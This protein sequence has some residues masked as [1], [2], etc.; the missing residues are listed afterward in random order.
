MPKRPY[1]I[2]L[3]C[4]GFIL[5]PP[6]CWCQ[7]YIHY[8]IE[9]GLP[10]NHVY[11]IEQDMQGFMWFATNMG[12]VKFD[13]KKFK[14]FTTESGL[15]TNDIWRIE[16]TANG[17][18]WYFAKSR[19]LG[20]IEND[21]VYTFPI[22][23]GRVQTPRIFSHYENQIIFWGEADSL[24]RGFYI[25]ENS[26]WHIRTKKIA[27]DNRRMILPNQNEIAVAIPQKIYDKNGKYL[28]SFRT[29]KNEALL[30]DEAAKDINKFTFFPERGLYFVLNQKL[31]SV[32]NTNDSTLH[33][34]KLFSPP[35]E[36]LTG[37]QG[38]PE[39]QQYGNNFQISQ[40]NEWAL[41][42]EKLNIIEYKYFPTKYPAIHTFK[43]KEGNFWLAG[44]NFGIIA[45]PQ[46]NLDNKYYF[47]DEK[48]QTVNYIQGK[49][50]VNTLNNGW[51]VYNENE[52]KFDLIINHVGKIYEMGY[53]KK[54]GIYY[55]FNNNSF[56]YG[57][58]LLHIKRVTR[59]Q[60][61][62]SGRDYKISIWAGAKTLLETPT[63]F[64]GLNG[65]RYFIIFDRNFSAI[66]NEDLP[67]VNGSKVLLDFKNKKYMFGDGVKFL[68]EKREIK[69]PLLQ[70]PINTAVI[71]NKDWILVGTEGFGAY[72]YDGG[73]TTYPLI[74][75]EGF[76]VNKII[77]D[78]SD[79]WIATSKGVH[80][81]TRH[82]NAFVQS[83]TLYD[84]DGLLNN[85]IN[86]ICLVGNRLFIAHDEGL[87]E[88]NL[89]Q[90]QFRKNVKVYFAGHPLYN[91]STKTLSIKYGN[92]LSLAFGVLCLP[93]QRYIK[94]Y[95]KLNKNEQ[96]QST[97]V[98]TLVV[99][100]QP[101]GQYE[102]S[103]KAIDQHNNVGETKIT[104]L[105]LPLWYQT[106]AFKIITALSIILAIVSITILYRKRIE[107]KRKAELVLSKTLSELE[108]K[109]LRSQMNPHFV[110]N[111][112]NAIQYFIVKNKTEL[113]EEYL[114]KFSRLVRLFFDYSRHDSLT[115]AQ[116]RDLLN[117]YLE[118][119]KLRFENKLEYNIT[120][121]DFIDDDESEVPSMILQPIVENAVNHGIFHKKGVGTINIAFRKI[122]EHSI[123]ITVEDDGIGIE[124]MKEIQKDSF[125]NYRSKSSQVIRERI[126]I[127]SESKISKWKV[128][129]NISDK[130]S[131]NP[132]QS[133]TI[134]TII[135][136]YNN[137]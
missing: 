78:N 122:D 109:A 92:T 125:G 67:H 3:C 113:S 15:P 99:G 98:T 34:V 114:A 110:F 49:L 121:D 36:Y 119:E 46:V 91:D 25:Q 31:I 33:A 88:I 71:F 14:V 72:F 103:F 56:W 53:H 133:G 81:F 84:E 63:G 130:K 18:L 129:Y 75:S 62:A 50:F 61:K 135:L 2:L 136:K 96:W 123:S 117:R 69:N 8:T 94:Y 134:V 43:D 76:I 9:Q 27:V 17:K 28:Y 131:I 82:D 47:P 4:I 58:D 100:T 102:I 73:E 115:V 90:S 80:K 124:A 51:Y 101:P 111:S 137:I 120:V 128:D 5:Y 79:I 20:Y 16:V 22:E 41:V 39:L 48:I 104:L 126:K 10:S 87:A 68:D 65:D 52:K 64:V 12:V 108:L 70:K 107:K 112:L 42:D 86:D 54:L 11:Q 38:F 35:F 29:T 23:D 1:T 106:L 7:Q 127:L 89:K 44:H 93:S 13:G 55:F 21:S 37:S 57:S 74:G 132:S 26:K 105:I 60:V 19:S 85:N 97:D 118:I 77:I 32:Y 24:Q 40:G 66:D 45:H 6:L 95:Y 30:T 59:I 83:E 116:E